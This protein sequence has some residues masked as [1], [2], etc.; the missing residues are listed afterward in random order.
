MWDSAIGVLLYYRLG[1]SKLINLSRGD[2]L[3][4]ATLFSNSIVTWRNQIRDLKTFFFPDN[5]L[6]LIG[7]KENVYTA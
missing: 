5:V 7:K 6:Y 1:A 3:I 2:H 4:I